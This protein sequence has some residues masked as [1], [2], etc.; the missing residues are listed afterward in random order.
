LNK[1]TYRGDVY[2]LLDTIL[3]GEKTKEKE[4]G[5]NRKK[6]LLKPLGNTEKYKNVDLSF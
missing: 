6:K 2:G 5:R 4:S 3:H 1:L